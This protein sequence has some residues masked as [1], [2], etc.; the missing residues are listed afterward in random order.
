MLETQNNMIIIHIPQP[1]D[2]ITIIDPYLSTKYNI[3]QTVVSKPIHSKFFGPTG[4]DIIWI[5]PKEQKWIW[6]KP[7]QYIW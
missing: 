5:Q 6:L 2:T 1:G 3:K 4:F 7:N